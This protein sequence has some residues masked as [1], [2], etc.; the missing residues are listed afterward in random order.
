MRTFLV[1]I[2]LLLIATY[3]HARKMNAGDWTSQESEQTW[4]ALSIADKQLSVMDWIGAKKQQSLNVD[5]QH[6]LANVADDPEMQM[7][8]EL[9]KT[10]GLGQELLPY[11]KGQQKPSVAK[12]SQN[13][14]ALA[15]AVV[16]CI[17]Q[18]MAQPVYQG[19]VIGMTNYMT[20]CS[21]KE[22]AIM[23]A[24]QVKQAN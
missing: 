1:F 12:P 4:K 2:S 16:A 3:A 13:E 15:K 5:A 9:T 19:L 8:G 7:L 6:P 22:R 24:R 18:E 11:N 20:I 23:K 14:D 21:T 10:I 17:D